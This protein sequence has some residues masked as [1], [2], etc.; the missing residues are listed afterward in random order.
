M[1]YNVVMTK[2]INASKYWSNYD[3]RWRVVWK[4]DE[5]KTHHLFYTKWWWEISVGEIP[6]GYT[7]VHKDGDYTNIS[8]DNFE[9][10]TLKENQRRTYKEYDRT[11]EFRQKMSKIKTGT[12]MSEEQRQK[13]AIQTA[14]NWA[15]GVFDKVHFGEHSHRWRGGQSKNYPAEFFEIREFIVERDRSTCQICYNKVT[16]RKKGHVHH[17]DGNREHN[18]QN[19]LLF[20]CYLCHGKVHSKSNEIPEIMALRSE[21]SWE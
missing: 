10:I 7:V 16:E 20:L 8:N 18:D 12:K 2:K 6:K 17:R 1:L 15:K 14:K 4:D 9:C 5:N 21:L 11:P 3:G 13:T 19:N